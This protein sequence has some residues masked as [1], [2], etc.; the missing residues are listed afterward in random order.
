[1]GEDLDVQPNDDARPPPLA[2]TRTLVDRFLTLWAAQDVV[3]TVALF[4]LDAVSYVHL[5]EDNIPAS[6]PKR[7]REEISEAL[8][9]NLAIWHVRVFKPT[10]IV[11]EGSIG[12]VQ[13]DFE[14]EH[15]IEREVFASTMRIIVTVCDDLISHI[16][17]FHDGPRVTAF[18]KLLDDRQ[19]RRQG[20]VS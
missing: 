15:L 20:V 1:V 6:G 13:V 7:G 5:D 9:G 14:Y 18:M 10:S 4:A 11:I 17:F 8:Y 2:A 19:R 16:E 12:R 3:E